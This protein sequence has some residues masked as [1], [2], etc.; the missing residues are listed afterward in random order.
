MERT[1]GISKQ[2]DFGRPSS[3]MIIFGDCMDVLSL[4]KSSYRDKI[5]CIYIDPPYNNGE[6]YNHYSDRKTQKNWINDLE[7]ILIFFQEL[8]S[9]DGSLWI[10]IDDRNMHYL[11]VLGDSIFGFENFISTI[12]WQHRITRENRN[13]FSNNHEYILVYAKNKIAFKKTRN[14][15]EGAGDAVNRYKNP[16]NDPRGPWQSVSAHVQDGHAAVSQY[17][18]LVAP[19]G[20]VHKLPKGRCWSYNQKRMYEEILKNNIWFGKEGNGVPRIKSFQKPDSHLLTP[21]TLWLAKDVGT[22]DSAKKHSLE[23]FN[24]RKV[25]DTPK[26]EELIKR[27]L[28]IATNDGD[29]VLDS[30]L[31]SG[32]TA[33]VAHKM[34]R[35]YIGIE[36]EKETLN[37]IIE[38]LI[39]VING[40][41]SGISKKNGWQGGGGFSLF[42]LNRT[43]IEKTDIN[44][45]KQ[46]E[47]ALAILGSGDNFQKTDQR[48]W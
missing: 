3:N 38:R 15:I 16:D 29:I 30:F 13:I 23:V 45:A 17:Y 26:P 14:K 34:N 46:M 5:K 41:S 37:Y 25:F 18:D 22:T 1:L 42:S 11:K 7:K 24:S 10:S 48:G 27:I 21:E 28:E 9:H 39:K 2:K 40:D 35:E 47:I 20:N 4:L 33:A 44:I 32:T 31:G 6:I 43:D 8:L 19:N 36:K 12:V